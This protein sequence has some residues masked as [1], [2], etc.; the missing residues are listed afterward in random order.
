[1]KTED[2][3]SRNFTSEFV[4]TTSRSGGPGGQNVN[5]VNTRVELRINIPASS[6]LSPE[7]KVI[8]CEKLKNRING[9]G[10][11]IISSQKGRTQMLNKQIVTEK[12]FDLI[13]RS[14]TVL[15]ERKPTKPSVSSKTE[16]IEKKR[17]RG[18][19]KK[20]RKEPGELSE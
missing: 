19:I 15:P 6:L 13:S 10:E 18:Y 7:E 5:K 4:F 20:L 12:F 2:L 1:M 3:R 17:K 11:L 16:R 9:R 14:L 8:I